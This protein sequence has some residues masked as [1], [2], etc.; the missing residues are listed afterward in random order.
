[1]F[2]EHREMLTESPQ[3]PRYLRDPAPVTLLIID[4]AF[5]VAV[6]FAGYIR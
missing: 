2:L 3:P 1:M 6:I 4:M 5:V